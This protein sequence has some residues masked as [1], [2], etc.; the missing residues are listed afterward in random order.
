[1]SNR[2]NFIRTAAVASVAVALNSL[3][4][5]RKE[6]IVPKKIKP[7][8]LSTGDLVLRLNRLLGKF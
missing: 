7:I 1:M 3:E 8:V 6:N 5:A 4:E 2:R